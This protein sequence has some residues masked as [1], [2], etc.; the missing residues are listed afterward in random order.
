MSWIHI[1]C[2]QN[3]WSMIL[4][5]FLCIP[6]C[7][8]LLNFDA[9]FMTNLPFKFIL[10]FQT[11][12]FHICNKLFDNSSWFIL[13][14]IDSIYYQ[15]SRLIFHSIQL[16]RVILSA[17]QDKFIDFIDVCFITH[18]ENSRLIP[19]LSSNHSSKSCFTNTCVSPN[20]QTSLMM[21]VKFLI[22][23]SSWEI[24]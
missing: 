6:L 16:N 13:I 23:T 17:H 21:K 15:A 20:H 9:S 5:L 1:A 2:Y 10:N 22:W 14:T 18:I 4:N 12:L 24:Q 11:S 8:D 7:L 3:N 19:T